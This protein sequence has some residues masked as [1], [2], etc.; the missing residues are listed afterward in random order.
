[1]VLVLLSSHSKLLVC[2]GLETR[3]KASITTEL[4]FRP[5]T[6][7]K[8]IHFILRLFAMSKPQCCCV[9]HIR[10][11]KHCRGRK[12]ERSQWANLGKFFLYKLV[13]LL[14]LLILQKMNSTQ[15]L[16]KHRY[17]ITLILRCNLFQLKPGLSHQEDADQKLP[18]WAEQT[19]ATVCAGGAS[20]VF[21]YAQIISVRRCKL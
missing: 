21:V 3:R 20:E 8:L 18:I 12:L 13:Y 15:C 5:S 7:I 4:K 2:A 19:T 17:L 10:C 9:G 1:M 11:T 14:A 16:N 6:R